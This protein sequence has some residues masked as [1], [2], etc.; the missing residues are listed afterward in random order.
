MNPLSD[1]GYVVLDNDYIEQ[2]AAEHRAKWHSNFFV[3]ECQD[4]QRERWEAEHNEPI[5]KDD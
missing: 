4:C 2:L 3:P 1:P 5:R